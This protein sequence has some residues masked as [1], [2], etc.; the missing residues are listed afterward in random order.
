MR[1]VILFI[2]TLTLA[3][4]SKAAPTVKDIMSAYNLLE[5]A[6]R[7]GGGAYA[8]QAMK[9]AQF[10]YEQAE[11][12]LKNGNDERAEE[13]R[14]ISEIRSKT[15]ISISRKK[16]Y[17]NE[18]Q[19]IE[20]QLDETSSIKKNFEGELRKNVTRLGEIKEKLAISQDRM[21]STA[22]DTLE[23]ASERINAAEGVSA[24]DFNPQALDE[25][26]QTYSIAEEDLT[27]G[28]YKK[29][30]ELGEKAIDLAEIAYERS[31]TKFE[32]RSGILDR[33]SR[34]YGA[35]TEPLKDGVKVNLHGVFAPSGKTILFDA[36]PSLDALA[37]V[38]AGYSNLPVTIEVY[39]SEQNSDDENIKIG[40]TQA[41]TVKNYLVSKGISP[42]RFKVTSAGLGVKEGVKEDSRIEVIIHLFE[43]SST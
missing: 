14:L 5:D 1:I 11:R 23:K 25:A 28:E 36:F 6:K 27:L 2:V 38:L 18:L 37:S 29:S 10:F 22:L 16:T 41:E 21:L 3:S 32:L 33:V 43:L 4:A 39:A 9:E 20:F 17:E 24:E 12:E 7:Q 42:Q 13:F 15:A 31:K 19:V 26:R 40:E 35:K 30:I 34:I 8:P